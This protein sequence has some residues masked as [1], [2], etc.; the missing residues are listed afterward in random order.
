MT[1]PLRQLS[2]QRC[3]AGWQMRYEHD[4]ASTR[5]AMR[6][7]L[8]LPDQVLRAP[9]PVLYWLS[10]KT[11][12]EENFIIKAGA[13]RVAAELGLALVAPDTSPRV[14]GVFEQDPDLGPGCGFYLNATAQPW[15]AHYQMFDYVSAELPALVEAL[16]PI[17]ADQRSVAGHSMGGHGALMCL[18]K[19][20]ERYRCGSVLAPVSNPSQSPWGQKVLGAYLGAERSLW[21]AWD[22]CALLAHAP[23]PRPLWVD[24]GEQDP[25]FEHLRSDILVTT[26][27]RYGYPLRH[28]LRPDY[29]HSYFYVASVIEEHLRWH[30]QWLA[31]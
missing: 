20:P 24:Q 6:F 21:Q 22:A 13:Q 4:A 9:V 1:S 14:G 23:E 19:R 3:F 16:F 15:V 10:G 2:R 5:C 30:A 18:F 7:A 27:A 12:N 11:C 17:C 28:T 29:D 8:Y 26:A 25:L 31:R